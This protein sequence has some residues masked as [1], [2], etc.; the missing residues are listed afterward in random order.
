MWMGGAPGGITDRLAL[1]ARR[2]L[3]SAGEREGDARP[4][5]AWMSVGAQALHYFNRPHAAVCRAPIEGPAAW[6]GAAWH[7]SDWMVALDAA[8]VDEIDAAL[9][10]ARAAGI[11]MGTLRREEFPLP[12][13][14]LRVLRVRMMASQEAV[15]RSCRRSTPP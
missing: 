6:R 9:R 11:A 13:L 14:G 2:T 7:E 12:R 15:F 10:A 8:T 4:D 3:G 1:C 5:D